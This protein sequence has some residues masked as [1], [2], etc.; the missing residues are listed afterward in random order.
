MQTKLDSKF[1]NLIN[2]ENRNFK[3]MR[4]VALIYLTLL[5]ASTIMAY[6]IVL[7]GP[8]SVPGSTLIYTFSFFWSSI[9]VELYGP[10]LAKKLIWESII[11]QFIFALLIN[12]VNTLPSPSYWNHKNAYDAVVGN[13]MRF[14]FA[15]M[16]GYL[17]SAFL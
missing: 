16:T 5:L 9:F 14:T 6:K 8:F 13:I 12:L 7:L 11:C 1:F 3:Y 15:G 4:I 17:M 2:F 10:N